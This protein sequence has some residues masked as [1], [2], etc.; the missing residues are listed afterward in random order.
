MEGKTKVFKR[1]CA[2]SEMMSMQILL[3]GLSYK[4]WEALYNRYVR[5]SPAVNSGTTKPTRR[6]RCR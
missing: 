2:N 1:G 6:L 5:L 4:F 3:L